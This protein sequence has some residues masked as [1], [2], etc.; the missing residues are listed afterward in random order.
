VLSQAFSKQVGGTSVGG[1]M[2]TALANNRGELVIPV[3]VTGTF[4]H[5]SFAP[6]VEKI[7]QM[8]LQ[9]MVPN[10]QNPGGMVSGMVGQIFGQKNKGQQQPA[11]GAQPATQ[12]QPAQSDN[13]LG[14]VLNQVL[15]GKK[16]NQQQQQPPPSPPQ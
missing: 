3:I 2:N 13:P 8:R 14:D 9:N 12:T 1:F 7:A 10:S 11:A 4:Q 5:P 16:K 6:D 15:G